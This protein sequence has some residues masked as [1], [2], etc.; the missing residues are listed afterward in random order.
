MKVQSTD[1]KLWWLI[2]ADEV[3]PV[4]GIPVVQAIKRF[5]ERFEFAQ[6]PTS[7]PGPNDGYKLQEG[8]IVIG[9]RTVAIKELTIYSDGISLEVYSNTD[10]NLACLDAVRDLGRELG[11]R[12]PQTP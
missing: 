4:S 11:L 9:G 8:R 1:S 12:D 5:V 10:D 7:M 3:R 2:K 6:A